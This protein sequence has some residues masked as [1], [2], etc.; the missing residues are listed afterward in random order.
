MK[1]IL[2]H[3]TSEENARKIEKEGFISDKKYKKKIRK[4]VALN[5]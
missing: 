3:G 2:Y 5:P 1:L 4:V